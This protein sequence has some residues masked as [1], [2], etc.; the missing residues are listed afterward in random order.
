[1][2]D[3]YTSMISS[4]WNVLWVDPSFKSLSYEETHGFSHP[5]RNTFWNPQKKRENEKEN[6]KTKTKPL[7]QRSGKVERCK[8]HVS[9]MVIVPHLGTCEAELATLCCHIVVEATCFDMHHEI[10]LAKTIP[11]V[12]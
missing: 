9:S 5:L 1:M 11:L 3:L 10:H 4:L 2:L 8:K 6:K 12:W 7:A